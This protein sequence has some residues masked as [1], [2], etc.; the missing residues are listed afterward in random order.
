MFIISWSPPF[1]LEGISVMYLIKITALT[2]SGEETLVLNVTTF[3]ETTSREHPDNNSCLVYTACV[4]AVTLAGEGIS[5]C[6]N[7]SRIAG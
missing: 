3:D 1:V 4:T 7:A 5:E 6:T 2:V